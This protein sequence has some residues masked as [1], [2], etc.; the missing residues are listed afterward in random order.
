MF[1]WPL[2]C[3]F[4]KQY[5]LPLSPLFLSKLQPDQSEPCLA[6]QL[7]VNGYKFRRRNSLIFIFAP[8]LYDGQLLE[9]GIC[10]KEFAPLG[11]NLFL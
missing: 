10:S 1:V 8:L 11:A 3:Y 9:K 4:S 6:A 2:A 5:F 7:K